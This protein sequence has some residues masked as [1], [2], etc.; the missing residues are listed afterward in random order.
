VRR[1]DVPDAL[2]TSP[3]S[4]GYVGSL[5]SRS[6]LNLWLGA[7]SL[8]S[9][10]F[11]GRTAY[12][13]LV[14]GEEL[15]RVAEGNRSRVLDVSAVRGIMFDRFGVP[16]VRRDVNPQLQVVPVDLPR[17]GKLR[18]EFTGQLATLLE[19]PAAVVDQF[20]QPL[21][22]RSYQ[23]VVMAE[24]LRHDQAIATAILSSRFP[25]VRLEVATRRHYLNED[26]LSLSHVVGYLGRIEAAEF[27]TAKARGFSP[28]AAIG[29]SGLE[30]ALEDTLHGQKGVEQI[31]VDATGRKKEVIA[32]QPSVAGKDVVLTLDVEA[33]RQLERALREELASRQLQRGA[34]VALDPRN[35]EILALV[36]LPS[37]D[38]NVFARGIQPAE[39]AALSDDDNRPLFA[40]AVQGAYPPGSTVK[41]IIAAAALQEGLINERTTYRSVGGIRVN[42]WFF[43]DWKAGGHG[44]TNVTLALAESV[45]TFFYYIGGGYGDVAGLGVERITQYLR[46]VGLGQQ[47]G[48][49]LPSEAT[50]LVPDPAWKERTTGQRWYIGDTYHL[51]IGQGDLLVTP[52]QVA[53]YTSVVANGGT[54]YRPRLVRA[55]QRSGD[56]PNPPQAPQVIRTAL[57]APEHLAVIRRGLR[58]AVQSGS[59][60]SL[61]TLPIAVAG[62]TGTAQWSST[63]HHHAWFTGYAP[64]DDPQVVLTVLVEEGGEG[65]VV[66]TPVAAK[67]FTWWSNARR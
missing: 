7:L 26:V 29:K 58:R 62:K 49:E 12:L 20:L 28:D 45:N 35:G 8:I 48:V 52:L 57:F 66:A 34:A 24:D 67:F 25:G 30:L 46:S 19:Q 59:A 63:R 3:L 44:P 32:Y 6:R 41:P 60:R 31:E 2:P 47:L 42:E 33:Q 61:A 53:V 15:R 54:L 36:S 27:A 1:A 64:A 56:A 50:G 39:L 17:D 38:S 14:R 10:L 13:Q 16:L 40:R 4:G 65:S 22:P 11:V 55:V 37:F 5:F 21:D 18:R 23:P 51:A 9:A 43:P